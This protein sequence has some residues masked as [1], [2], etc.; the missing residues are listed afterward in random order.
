MAERTFTDEELNDIRGTVKAIAEGENRTITDLAKEAGIPFGTFSGFVAG[1]YTGKNENIAAKVEIWLASREEHKRASAQVPRAPGFITTPSAAIFLEKLRFAQV[2]PE[3]CVIAGGAGLGKTMTAKRYT[4]TNPNVWLATMDPSTA[5]VNPMLN[6]IA[7]TLGLV[8]RSNAKLPRAI[9]N[10][11]ANSG[12]L[13]IVDEA[14]HLKT[15]ALD[16]LRSLYD[17]HE[18]GLGLIGNE[19]VYARLEGGSRK[20]AFA[21]I[22]SRIGERVS[23]ARPRAEDMCALIKAWDVTDP[24]E[25]RLLK[26]IAAKPGALRGM[27]K[28]LQVATMLAAGAG[29]TRDIRHIRAAYARHTVTH[30]AAAA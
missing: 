4:A 25:I 28:V 27:T 21:Q 5:T 2:M 14:Q 3:I 13:L 6:E 29:E 11:L 16:M 19:S 18:V 22:F 23:Q 12:G 24:A 10:K 30:D 20:A 1:T 7:T 9:G 8:E 17:R 26:A 15:E